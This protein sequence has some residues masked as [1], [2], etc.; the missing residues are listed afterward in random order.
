MASI[1]MCSLSG[2]ITNTVGALSSSMK[3]I[4]G[5]ARRVLRATKIAPRCV[6]AK[7][8]SNVAMS[9]GPR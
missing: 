1:P 3:A 4:S 6:V 9:F 8:V 7:R 2:A 5:A